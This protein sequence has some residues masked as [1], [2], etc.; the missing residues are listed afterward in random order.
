MNP[1]NKALGGDVSF[2]R[3]WSTHNIVAV[4]VETLEPVSG[5]EKK[6]GATPRLSLLQRQRLAWGRQLGRLPSE[7]LKKNDDPDALFHLHK[8]TRKRKNMS[9]DSFFLGG[10]SLMASGLQS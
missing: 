10:D 8:S 3:T 1:T 9:S 2:G 6:G 4:L 5:P 7:L